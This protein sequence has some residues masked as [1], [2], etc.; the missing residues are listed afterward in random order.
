MIWLR[1]LGSGGYLGEVILFDAALTDQEILDIN[2][3]LSVKWDIPL[4]V[5]GGSAANGAALVG[6]GLLGASNPSPGTGATGV[7]PGGLSLSW[8]GAIGPDIYAYDV[9]LK[10]SLDPD[11]VLVSSNQSST[12][13]T[14]PEELSFGQYTWRVDTRQDGSVVATGAVWS[15][16]TIPWVFTV[17]TNSASSFSKTITL[18]DFTS[19]TQLLAKLHVIPNGDAWDRNGRVY[20]QTPNGDVDLVKFITGFCVETWHTVDITRLRPLLTGMVTIRGEIIHYTGNWGMDFSIG[21]DTGRQPGST[22]GVES[23][24][25]SFRNL[26]VDPRNTDPNCHTAGRP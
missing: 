24:N 5:S 1:T 10:S 14:P 20:L 12:S 16:T 11:F 21:G 4:E 2:T 8:T 7:D 6:S 25:G 13:Y 15:F 18:P 23:G 26:V 3:Y 22:D 9:Y 19:N 17:V